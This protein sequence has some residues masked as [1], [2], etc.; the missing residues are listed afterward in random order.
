M[1]LKLI[2]INKIGTNFKPVLADAV[3]NYAG[4]KLVDYDKSGYTNRGYAED[5][6]NVNMDRFQK[7]V[8][9]L[10]DNKVKV[11]MGAIDT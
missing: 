1:D 11:A 4:A 10:K 6:I 8:V 5:T 3:A 2:Y 7:E 9:I